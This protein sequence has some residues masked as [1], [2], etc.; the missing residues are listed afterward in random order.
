M[1]ITG[2]TNLLNTLNQYTIDSFPKSSIL[3]GERGCGKHL[4]SSYIA[5]MLKLSLIDITEN[6]SQ[7]LI[8]S[9]YEN[10]IPAIYL[11]NTSK[12]TEKEQ[13]MILK[14]FASNRDRNFLRCIHPFSSYYYKCHKKL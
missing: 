1:N 3:V 7:E 11:I 12:I 10:P 8:T 6:I 4:I 14:F 5:E 9:I 13:N 2:Q